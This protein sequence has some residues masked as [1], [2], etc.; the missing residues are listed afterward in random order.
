MDFHIIIFGCLFITYC[1][2][3][4]HDLFLL[5]F[6]CLLECWWLLFFTLGFS[7]VFS[8]Y[9]ITTCVTCKQS[10]SSAVPGSLPLTLLTLQ[11][12]IHFTGLE[13]GHLPPPAAIPRFSHP[14]GK[15][16]NHCKWVRS[17]QNR[18]GRN[19]PHLTNQAGNNVHY[20]TSVLVLCLLAIT[21]QWGS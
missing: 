2:I 5:L 20:I 12:P 7:T 21:R 6:D 17:A 4:L 14:I 3:T 10:A 8:L 13:W 9:F 11:L 1:N 16:G 15:P 18:D 19:N